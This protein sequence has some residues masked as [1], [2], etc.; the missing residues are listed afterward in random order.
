MSIGDKMSEKYYNYNDLQQ[1]QENAKRFDYEIDKKS[2]LKSM[3][4]LEQK[5]VLFYSK[6]PYD[7]F[8]YLDSLN[9][10]QTNIMLSEL[11]NEEISKLIDQFTAED[12]KS[13]YSSFSNTILVNRFI[14]NDKN[15]FVH[16]DELDLERKIELL[17][18]SKVN[19]Q[20]ATQE[21]YNTLTT[22]EKQ[23]VETKITSTEGSLVVDNVI[24]NSKL[25]SEDEIT[26]DMEM[27]EFKLNEQE[28]RNEEFKDENQKETNQKEKQP[29]E[30]ELQNEEFK[31]EKSTE[32]NDFL[33][34]K[35]REY[36]EKN[37][38]FN[39]LDISV[40]NLFD[41]LSDELKAIVINDF[42]LFL[43]EQKNKLSNKESQQDVLNEF[44]K[45][46]EDCET[47]IINNVKQIQ[48]QNQEEIINEQFNNVKTL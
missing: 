12:K 2:F 7:V 33:K 44:Q 5:M 25:D 22:Q 37:P 41:A 26:E 32:I 24:D 48:L 28:L 20:V 11:T 8:N 47:E 39:N 19:T 14:A 35:L 1:M 42:N 36:K 15:S 10:E 4:P 18:S 27:Q 16:I 3:N 29:E 34:S 40:S 6:R 17:D 13:F 38:K 21:I 46:K 9:N 30:Q 23:K 45:S 43:E 31:Q